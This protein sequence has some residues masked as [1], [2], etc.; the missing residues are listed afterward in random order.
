MKKLFSLLLLVLTGLVVFAQTS[1]EEKV[2]SRVEALTRAIF[3]TKDSVALK[4]L[5]SENVSY[6]HSG[7]A[8]E[9]KAAMVTNAAIS[10]TTYRNKSFEKV[11]IDVKGKTAIV[12]H[13]FRAGSVDDKGVET[14][15]N[16]AV[17]QVW[18][19]EGRNWR[20]WARQAVKVLP[21]S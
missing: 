8:V 4:D 20:I 15:L 13:N 5:V 7:G 16:I 2:W 9:N 11:S 19:K 17:L 12:R 10:P 1:R 21:K 6:G 3:E 18:K 14:P